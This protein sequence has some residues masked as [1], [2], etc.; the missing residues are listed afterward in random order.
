MPN[1]FPK[2][3]R[4][5]QNLPEICRCRW[6]RC[7]ASGGAGI[8]EFNR[9]YDLLTENQMIIERFDQPFNIANDPRF[10]A[11]RIISRSADAAATGNN[12][13]RQSSSANC[14]D[15]IAV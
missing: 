9:Q 8:F 4:G 6:Q 12:F 13:V 15:G 11:G 14:R 10:A 1:L 3:H 5:R 2:L 7:P